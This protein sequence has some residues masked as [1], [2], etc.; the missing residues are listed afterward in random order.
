MPNWLEKHGKATE[1][2][3][4]ISFELESIANAFQV[5]GNDVMYNTLK[6][7][8]KDVCTAQRVVSRAVSESISEDAKRIQGHSKAILEATLAGIISNTPPVESGVQ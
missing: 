4:H 6:S 5:T 1:M 3:L 2:L 8:G 7:I